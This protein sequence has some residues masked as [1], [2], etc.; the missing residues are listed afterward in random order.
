VRFHKTLRHTAPSFIH[1]S[2]FGKCER[3][4]L[5]SCF[6][7]PEQRHMVT[8]RCTLPERIERSKVDLGTCMS[9]IGGFFEPILSLKVVLWKTSSFAVQYAQFILSVG[10][11]GLSTLENFAH[12]WFANE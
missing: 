5:F 10:I 11:T 8:I 7:K 6:L 4:S 1:H 2:K 3:I 9:L 12:G